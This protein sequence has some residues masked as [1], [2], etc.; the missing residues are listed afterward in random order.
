M[1]IGTLKCTVSEDNLILD[2]FDN[3]NRNSPAWRIKFTKT[4]TIK[5]NKVGD[6]GPALN[7]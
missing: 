7:Y 6:A 2:N 4:M 1:L 3:L 5:N